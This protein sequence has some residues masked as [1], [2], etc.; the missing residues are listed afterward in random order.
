MSL[1]TL[2]KNPLTTYARVYFW[3]LYSIPLVYMSVFMPRP[4]FFSKSLLNLLQYC[5]CFMFWF[6]FGRKACGILAPQPGI[7]PVPPALEGEVLSTG[8]PG[9]SQDHTV[10]I[11]AAL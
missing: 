3:A 6:I 2:V 8:P 9:R 7:E 11:T 1:G 4:H 5:F 10:L